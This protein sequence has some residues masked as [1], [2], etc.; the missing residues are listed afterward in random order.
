MSKAARRL[1][2]RRARRADD[3]SMTVVVVASLGVIGLALVA[4]LAVTSA[5]I[6]AHR[7]RASADLGALAGAIEVAR[8]ADPAVA[9]VRSAQVV[10]RN[11]AT[12]S[13]C[14][15]EPDGSVVVV[16]SASVSWTLPA[17]GPLTAKARARAGPSP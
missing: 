13:G 7:A 4:A 5:V 11:A 16:V 12:M 6:A 10:R 14:R 2:H 1:E 9:C 15:V 17:A 3:G 8:G